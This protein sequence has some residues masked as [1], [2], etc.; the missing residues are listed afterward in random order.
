[1]GSK[2]INES[3]QTIQK[4]IDDPKDNKKRDDAQDS[5]NSLYA[6][7]EAIIRCTGRPPKHSI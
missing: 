5:V 2:N 6:T 1:M 7:F 4:F 3:L